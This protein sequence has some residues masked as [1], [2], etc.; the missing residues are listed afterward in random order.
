MSTPNIHEKSKGSKIGKWNMTKQPRHL[1][2]YLNTIPIIFKTTC[3]RKI[4]A[5]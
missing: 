1:E 3:R 4:E 2:P 5:N